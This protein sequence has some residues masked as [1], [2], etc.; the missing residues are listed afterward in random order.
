MLL[1]N[2]RHLSLTLQTRLQSNID[3]SALFE[4]KPLITVTEA[5]INKEMSRKRSI[6]FFFFCFWWRILNF[7]NRALEYLRVFMV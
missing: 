1:L 4:A 3:L 7:P 6:L 2:G 5:I